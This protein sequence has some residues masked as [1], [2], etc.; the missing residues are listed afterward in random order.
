MLIGLAD[1]GCCWVQ[2]DALW[3]TVKAM[4]GTRGCTPC[5][6]ALAWVH[7]HGDDVFPLPGSRSIEQCEECVAAFNINLSK[8]ELSELESVL[9]QD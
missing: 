6:V 5:Q 4:A 7:A 1:F 9:A 8:L 2:N 3:E